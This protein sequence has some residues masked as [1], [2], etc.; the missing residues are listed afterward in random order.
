MML[1]SCSARP[2]AT[3]LASGASIAPAN[4]AAAG[5]ILTSSEPAAGSVVQ[6][7]V[8]TIK[9]HFNPP[10][11]LVEI[12]VSGPGGTMPMMVTAVGEVSDYSLPV[13]DLGPGRYSVNWKATAAGQAYGGNFAFTVK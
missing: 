13:N 2:A 6:R 7:P 5:S 4:S 3:P 12:T 11:R 10:A 8:D 1:A 9:L